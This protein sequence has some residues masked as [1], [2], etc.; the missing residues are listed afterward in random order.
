MW[1][2]LWGRTKWL[3]GPG[4]VVELAEGDPGRGGGRAKVLL[5]PTRWTLAHVASN[6]G[7]WH[8]QRLT[9]HGWLKGYFGLKLG[10]KFRLRFGDVL[11]RV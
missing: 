3:G 5:R 2:Q 8:S 1:H 4:G 9:S 11:G 6:V 7:R 10:L